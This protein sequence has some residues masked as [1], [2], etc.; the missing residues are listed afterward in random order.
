VRIGEWLG[1]AGPFL[2]LLFVSALFG[3]LVGPEFFRPANLELIARQ[4]AIVG[5]AALGMTLVI[6]AGGIDLSVGSIIALATVVVA[7]LLRGGGGPPAAA[8]G[9]IAAGALCGAATGLLVTRLQ[10]IPF[11]VS[12]G[13]MLLVRGAAKGL[14]GE[15][16][17]EAPATWLNDLLRTLASGEGFLPWGLWLLAFLALVVAG[18]LR[19]TRFGRHVLAVGSNERTARLCGIAVDRVKV[20]VYTISGALAGLAGVLQFAKLSVGDPT[21]ATGLELD[22]IAAVIIGGGSLLGGKGTALGTLVGATLMTV[23]QI[24]CSQ[25]G[26]PNWVQQIVTGVVIVAA[27]ALDRWRQGRAIKA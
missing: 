18:V 11:I 17:L 1:R 16:R 21:V 27:V 10:V 15:R 6:A 26:L 14:A 25:K 24:G 3:V 23:I 12:L 4:T 19:Y 7:Q 20:A 8:L 22:V 13:M 2:G 5:T 9:G